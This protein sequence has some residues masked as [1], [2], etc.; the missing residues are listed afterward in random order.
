MGP[1]LLAGIAYV[2]F[3]AVGMLVLVG[4]AGAFYAHGFWDGLGLIQDWFSPFNFAN[5]IL[6]LLLCSP[7]LVCL[8]AADKLEKRR[9]K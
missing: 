9:M 3:F 8:W 1:K 7:G 2:N 6:I 4:I 5:Y